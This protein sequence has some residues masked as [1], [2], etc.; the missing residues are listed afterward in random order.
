MHICWNFTAAGEGKKKQ[1]KNHKTQKT[2]QRFNCCEVCSPAE[3]RVV[4]L[5]SSGAAGLGLG[6]CS[7]SALLWDTGAIVVAAPLP[8]PGTPLPGLDSSPKIAM[9]QE[10]T[11]VRYV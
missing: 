8:A 10:F 11:S 5:A 6:F 3:G 4:H 2:T 9:V 1:T 7:H